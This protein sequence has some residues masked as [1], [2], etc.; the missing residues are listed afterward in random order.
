MNTLRARDSKSTRAAHGAAA[1][2]AAV[3]A[4][5]GAAVADEADGLAVGAAAGL[6]GEREEEGGNVAGGEREGEWE[7]GLRGVAGVEMPGSAQV[8]AGSNALARLTTPP[9]HSHACTQPSQPTCM[10]PVPSHPTC[11]EPTCTEPTCTEP[12]GCMT[13]SSPSSPPRCCPSPCALA[14]PRMAPLLPR[15]HGAEGG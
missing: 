11:T 8:G 4:A 3:A 12:D 7:R 15:T 10:G 6:Q 2:P 9:V 5:K 14:P 13:V 1:A